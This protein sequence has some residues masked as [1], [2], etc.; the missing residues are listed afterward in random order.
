MITSI[1]NIDLIRNVINN[2]LLYKKC[3][4]PSFGLLSRQS[5]DSS[6]VNFSLNLR[7][8]RPIRVEHN[9]F[10]FHV[11]CGKCAVCRKK[12][13]NEWYVRLVEESKQHVCNLFITLTYDDDHLNYFN[14]TPCLVKRDVQLFMKRFRKHL[15]E[16]Y[17]IKNL[18][19]F[20]V[21]EYGPDTLRPH[22]HAL[23]F[24]LPA[25]WNFVRNFD[26]NTQLLKIWQKG[27]V[28]VGKL[29]DQRIKYCAKYCTYATTLPDKYKLKEIID[30]KGHVIKNPLR[31][32]TCCSKYIGI[33]FLTIKMINYYK[34]SR[35]LLYK[36]N[37]YDYP[38]PRYYREKIFT[39]EEMEENFIMAMASIASYNM[40]C[41]LVYKDN[42][43]AY[44]S[45][46]KRLHEQF[47]KKIRDKSNK[48]TYTV[49]GIS[50][51]KL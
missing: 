24:G 18:K 42:K 6:F 41:D 51:T 49:K 20:L 34:S 11:G 27:F 31:V 26:I 29:N 30:N 22:Y 37:G 43:R 33:G 44:F 17:G 19:Y 40:A 46:V 25:K 1:K 35:N 2:P 38:L 32:F 45:D 13:S 23:I 12:R 10:Y 14:G 50:R 9:G 5:V 3:D 8:M 15:Y 39:R 28:R 4:L 47:I 16:L 21:G 7:C 36:T 48:K